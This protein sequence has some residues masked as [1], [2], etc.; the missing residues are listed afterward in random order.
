MDSA[1]LTEWMA[2]YEYKHQLKLE[3]AG[4]KVPNRRGLDE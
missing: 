4:G 1:E 2:F 3:T